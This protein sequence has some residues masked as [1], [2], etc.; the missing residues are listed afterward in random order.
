M[1]IYPVR[2]FIMRFEL[3]EKLKY[4]IDISTYLMV[5]LK[6]NIDGST[7]QQSCPLCILVQL[8]LDVIK[9]CSQVLFNKQT[10]SVA[11]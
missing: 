9:D 5:N 4:E 10:F 7:A 2:N 3:E 6:Q 1:F 8:F 11:V